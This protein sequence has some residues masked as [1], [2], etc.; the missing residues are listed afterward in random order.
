MA[1]ATTCGLDGFCDGGGACRKYASG[2][3]CAAATCTGSTLTS[4]ATCNG[5]GTCSTPT[6]S[7]CSPYVCGTGACKTT[8]ATNADC[9]GPLF[10]CTGTACTPATN[11]TV[12]LKE[13]NIGSTQQITPNFRII[14]NGTSAVPLSELTVRYWYTIDIAAPTQSPNCDYTLLPGNCP[15]LVYSAA[16]FV[17]VSPARTGADYYFQ[18]GF[19]AAAGSLAANGGGAT[20][21]IQLRWNKTTF[22][23]Y[24]QT[25][26]Y[27]YN[28]AAAYT[29]TTKVTVYRNGTLIYG[30]EP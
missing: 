5:G 30:T 1:A 2:T 19:T 7:S 16:S 4:S 11:L 6:T 24:D 8:C 21:D 20:G 18:F 26:D 15:A 28:A 25:N 13:I 29:A 3:Q 23:N 10:V 22:T 27:S 14:N 9:L 12:Q 17:A